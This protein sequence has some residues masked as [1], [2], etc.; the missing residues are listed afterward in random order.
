MLTRWPDRVPLIEFTSCPD[1]TSV[2]CVF[3]IPIC[4]RGKNPWLHCAALI[5]KQHCVCAASSDREANSLES[6][7]LQTWLHNFRLNQ[8]HLARTHTLLILSIDQV[9]LSHQLPKSQIPSFVSLASLFS[10]HVS[11]NEQNQLWS[12]QIQIFSRLDFTK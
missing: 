2:S 6:F 1:T 9:I 10:W 11:I 8:S 3:L 5:C 12:L 7:H 4:C